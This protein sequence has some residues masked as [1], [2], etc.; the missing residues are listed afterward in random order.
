MKNSFLSL[1]SLGLLLCAAPFVVATMLDPHFGESGRVEL[2]L[3]VYGN[4]ANAVV[5]Q[6]DGKIIGAGYA[7]NAAKKD[8]LLF[9]IL[10]DGSLDPE[11]NLDG[12]VTSTVGSHDDEVLALALQKDGKIIA[13]GYSSEGSTRNFALVRYNPNG[14]IDRT[15]GLEGRVVT[16]V[17]NSHDEI[18][19][20]TVQPDGRIVFVGSAQ[21]SQ[22]RVVVLGRY[23]A[24]GSPDPDFGEGGFSLNMVG[25]DAQVEG[26]AVDNQGRILVSGSY[27]D[28]SRRSL[29]VLGFTE[30]GLL[31]PDFADEGIALPADQGHYSEGYGMFVDPKGT[32]WVAGSVGE[33]EE[34]SAALFRFTAQGEPDSSFENQGVLIT[35]VGPQDDVLYSVVVSEEMLAAAGFRTLNGERAF[36]L[37]TYEQKS[38]TLREQSSILTQPDAFMV[39][40]MLVTEND[41]KHLSTALAVVSPDSLVVV[42]EQQEAQTASVSKYIK[43]MAPEQPLLVSTGKSNTGN[44][45]IFTGQAYDVTRTTAIVPVDISPGFA[46]VSKRGLVFGTAPNPILKD[47]SEG[48]EKT[49]D[50]APKMLSLSPQNGSAT[51]NSGVTLS[52]STDVDATCKYSTSPGTAY[53]QMPRTFST[54]GGKNHSQLLNNLEIKQHLYYVRCKNTSTGKVNTSDGIISFTVRAAN[55][56]ITDTTP[57]NITNATKDTFQSTEDVILSVTTDEKATCKYSKDTDVA[58]DLMSDTDTLTATEEG[59]EHKATL[60]ALEAG[61]YTYYVRCQDLAGNKNIVGEKIEFTVLITAPPAPN[62]LLNSMGNFLVGT[63]FAQTQTTGS[64][65]T[66]TQT[67]NTT[68]TVKKTEEKEDFLEEG[69]T[70]NGAGTGAFSVQLENLKP[71]TFFYARAYVMSEGSVYYGNEIGFRT[72]D[73]CAVATAAYG[74][75]FHPAVQVLRDFRDQF[76]SSSSWG[77]VVMQGYYQYSPKVAD[78]IS[79]N[80]TLR[81]FMQVLLLPVVGLAWLLMHGGTVVLLVALV[82]SIAVFRSRH[83]GTL[84][85]RS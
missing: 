19:G 15:F 25:L 2:E 77:R 17:G 8:F 37:I 47:E 51:A 59:K 21:G 81:Q 68:D 62:T 6:S 40:N 83:Y 18:T 60:D 27:T 36:L 71:G 11:F 52:V 22:G 43:A 3:G 45:S 84:S 42:G 20:V 41:D 14:S 28:G 57:P 85:S 35:S 48:S 80:E 39:A 46:S 66:Q 65:Q 56:T 16:P 67:T 32:I 30:K 72:A 61:T 73:S 63:A 74:S 34:R 33:F 12:L 49:S 58:Y 31:D 10:A 4:R 24:N 54:T 13:A 55:P 7:A 50:D 26:V 82:L 69:S 5:V 23:L 29:M 1:L 44:A 70:E 9:R 78:F 75:L 79:Q 64:P 76:L 38:K 53:E